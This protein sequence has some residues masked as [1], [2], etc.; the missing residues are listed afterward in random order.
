MNF[1]TDGGVP[2]S[3]DRYDRWDRDTLI[4][5]PVDPKHARR[6]GG[7]L[8][9]ADELREMLRTVRMLE[10]EHLVRPRQRHEEEAA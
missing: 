9:Q 4:L 5:I 6:F 3:I 10:G 1:K 2:Y 8:L 7:L